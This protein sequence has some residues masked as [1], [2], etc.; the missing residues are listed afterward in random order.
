MVP[1]FSDD[2][3]RALTSPQASSS[4]L[5]AP[6]QTPRVTSPAASSLVGKKPTPTTIRRS[7]A[8]SSIAQPTPTRNRTVS[9]APVSV[10][11]LSKLQIQIEELT[12]ALQQSEISRKALEVQTAS[13]IVSLAQL[14]ERFDAREAE[15]E[16]QQKNSANLQEALESSEERISEMLKVVEDCRVDVAS[17][18]A[19]A[20]TFTTT[21]NEL[22]KRVNLLD[23]EVL[24]DDGKLPSLAR[25]MGDVDVA[26][27]SDRDRVIMLEEKLDEVLAKVDEVCALGRTPPPS[28]GSRNKTKSL[29]GNVPPGKQRKHSIARAMDGDD[30]ASPISGVN[31][32]RYEPLLNIEKGDSDSPGSRDR[33]LSRASISAS[34][35]HMGQA[36]APAG[37]VVFPSAAKIPKAPY[38][39][40]HAEFRFPR[41][42]TTG[43]ISTRTSVNGE[44]RTST[45]VVSRGHTRT[46]SFDQNKAS[47][48]SP[49]AYA[50]TD[51]D[52]TEQIR[53]RRT[54][55]VK[56]SPPAIVV[57]RKQGFDNDRGNESSISDA[58]LSVSLSEFDVPSTAWESDSGKD[59][60]SLL[61]Q[62]QPSFGFIT[63][64]DEGPL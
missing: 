54:S 20:S 27:A 15:L 41:Q 55:S 7:L 26:M 37:T 52:V 59:P 64:D 39:G 2:L 36:S 53:P 42:G 3:I 44:T 61:H 21:A 60:R 10:P 63:T 62:P 14:T 49:T 19:Q 30:E 9:G 16:L 8:L 18:V 29:I 45:P 50:E 24:R 58:P 31:P 33:R 57:T 28:S 25:E 12:A 43:S 32:F 5:A 6:S 51:E 40:N 17:C 11:G 38:T 48:E 35:H 4:S 1:R 13:C 22:Q 56:R 47:V 23:R 46:N 34:L